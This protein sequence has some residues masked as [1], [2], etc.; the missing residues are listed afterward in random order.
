[1]LFLACSFAIDSA[2]DWEVERMLRQQRE[3]RV[4]AE[5]IRMA[6]LAL[7]GHYAHNDDS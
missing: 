7:E 6:M 3:A 5:R 2:R 1:M 4:S